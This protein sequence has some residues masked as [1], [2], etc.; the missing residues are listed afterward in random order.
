MTSFLNGDKRRAHHPTR[1]CI[2]PGTEY[3]KSRGQSSTQYPRIPMNNFPKRK[4][5]ALK[6]PGTVSNE[7]VEFIVLRVPRLRV[8]L[9][10]PAKQAVRIQQRVLELPLLPAQR[11]S[12]S[13]LAHQLP[14]PGSPR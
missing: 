4:S 6:A 7:T 14:A 9:W 2:T 3:A 5:P 10:I 11:R 12:T 8:P 1:T 13:P